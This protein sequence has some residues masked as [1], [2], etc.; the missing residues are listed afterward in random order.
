M[1]KLNLPF[2]AIDCVISINA[3]FKSITFYS[4]DKKN[5]SNVIIE[6]ETYKAKPFEQ[7]FYEMLKNCVALRFKNAQRFGRVALILPDSLF[8]MDTI[9]IPIIQKKAMANSLNLAIDA[10][11]KNSK[12][13]KFVTSPLTR[14]KK[15]ATYSI[16]GVR[17]EIIAKV[18]DAIER[19]GASLCGITFNAS[20]MVNGAMALNSKLKTAS[21]LLLDIKEEYSFFAFVVRGKVMGYYSLPFGHSVIKDDIVKDE[22]ALFDHTAGDLLVLNADEKAKSKH[23]TSLG[24][25]D[26]KQEQALENLDLEDDLEEDNQ[27][28]NALYKRLNRK[29]PKFML[30]PTPET[31]EG[32][33]IEN[34]RIFVKWALELLRNNADVLALGSIDTVYVNMPDNFN[35]VLKA[36]DGE[37]EQNKVAFQPLAQ[38]K[39]NQVNKVN[40]SLYGGLLIKKYN[41]KNNF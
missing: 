37:Q 16:L 33:E 23:I 20:A 30:R 24:M 19:A 3:D 22:I 27:R 38:N 36:I 31:K 6:Q 5:K 10:L 35:H 32:F 1:F 25:T 9:K 12:E 40:L 29:L 34:F 8:L 18:T 17:K 11:Y 39:Q 13:I 4:I 41:T 7:D 21:Y 2:S 15:T 14:D 28:V 26:D